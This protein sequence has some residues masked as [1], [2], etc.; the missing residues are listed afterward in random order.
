MTQ[1][2]ASG[3]PIR[4]PFVDIPRQHRPLKEELLKA[5]ERVLDHGQFVL[6]PEVAEFE[7]RFAALC[8]VRYAVGVDNG[9]NALTLS[10]RALGIGPGDEVITAAN[11]FLASASSIALAGARPV[12]VDVLSDLTIDPE[13]VERAITPRTKA[14]MPVHLT[15]RPTDMAAIREVAT[16]RGVA[17]VEDAAQAVGARSQGKRVGSLGAAGC[18]SLHPLKILNAVGDGGVITTDDCAL[19]DYLVKA[20]NHG[21]KGRDECEFWSLNSRLDT[22]QAAMLLVKLRRLDETIA[23]RRAMASFYGER[24][25][26]LVTVPVERPGDLPVYQTYVIQ[27]QRR[28]ELQQH[29]QERGVDSKVHYPLPIH[30]QQAARELGYRPGDFPVTERLSSTILSLPIH[31]ELSGDQLQHVVDSVREF[32]DAK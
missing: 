3:T 17:I 9:T 7:E 24:L 6:G 29:L 4:V 28:D 15:G 10:L 5:C 2:K 13:Q 22:L 8:G 14:V 26:D 12:L 18:F 21:L 25:A 19:R 31:P 11:S 30:L 16:R 20:R 27:C 32:Y 1:Q 23:S